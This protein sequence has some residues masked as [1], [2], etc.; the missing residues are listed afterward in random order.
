MPIAPLSTTH[1][2]H[3]CTVRKAVST[4]LA[5]DYRCGDEPKLIGAI[6]RGIGTRLPDLEIKEIIYA[7][8]ERASTEGE[9]L[10]ALL[11][12]NEPA[13]IGATA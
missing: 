8:W 9:I 3:D 13:E 11:S 5:G 7:G 10:A 4:W 6:R 2:P 12:A 1:R